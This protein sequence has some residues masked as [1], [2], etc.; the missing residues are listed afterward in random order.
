MVVGCGLSKESIDV[1]NCRGEDLRLG[2]GLIV[3]DED[4]ICGWGA[5]LWLF[6]GFSSVILKAEAR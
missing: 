5:S 1:N 6:D 4:K 2:F 3:E